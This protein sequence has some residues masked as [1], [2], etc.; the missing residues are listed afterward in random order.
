MKLIHLSDLHLGKKVCGFSLIEDQKHILEQILEIIEDEQPQGVMLAGDLYDK[1]VPSVEAVQLFDWFLEQLVAAGCSVYAI[2]GNHDSAERLAFGAGLM[3]SNNVY[4]SAVYNGQIQKV[5][6][7]DD[8]GPAYIWLMPFIKPASVRHGLKQTEEK[9]E[10]ITNYQD[11]AELVVRHMDIDRTVRNVLIAHQF[12]T[13]ASCC[14]SEELNVGG[15]DQISADTFAEFD[16]V[17]LGHIHSPQKMGRETVRYCGTPLKY[18]FSEAEQT[19]S[20]TVVTLLEK[21]RV[22]LKTV[23]L[24]PLRE[25]R[26]I[27]G[28]YMELMDRKSYTEQGRMDY[29]HITLTDEED[30]PDGIH[31]LRT[32]YPNLMQ[33]EYDNLR[34]RADQQIIT[35]DDQI[36][37]S[38]QEV[39]EEFFE[40]QNNQ[41]M[42]D[43]QR[44]FVLELIEKMK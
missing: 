19:K 29:V 7:T 18:S 27:K 35:M 16:Y 43:A 12:V 8:Y 6:V 42:N 14:E 37:K 39:F 26:K 44:E 25:M 23:P 11:A 24:T 22:E 36:Q 21:G 20:V 32:V 3:K 10:N 13:G 31:R 5:E 4:F 17:A 33:L 1:S 30:I 9:I 40:L 2:S 34:T 41:P 38:E 28:T 15:I